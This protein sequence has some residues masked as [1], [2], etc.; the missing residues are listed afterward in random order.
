MSRIN[1]A[2]MV[3][4]SGLLLLPVAVQAESLREYHER[5]CETGVEESCQRAADMR[6]GEE[7]A[8]RI[9]ELGDRFAR[10]V[11]RERLEL[12]NKPLLGQA[13]PEVLED[14]FN[15]EAG[16]GIAQAISDEVIQLCAE[17][18]NNH[19]RN[20]KMWWPTNAVGEP[21]WSTIYYYIVEHYYGYCLRSAL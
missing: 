6:A 3:F 11:E 21:D 10:Q 5:Q 8:E 16:N 7:H 4:I 20:R 18:Y 19:W 12:Q 9:V 1:R 14:Y 2:S 17:H 15:A 13:Y